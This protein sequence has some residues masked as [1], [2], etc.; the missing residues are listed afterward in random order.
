MQPVGGNVYHVCRAA[1]WSWRDELPLLWGGESP[2]KEE[3][4][5]GVNW[6]PREMP[7]DEEYAF[8]DANVEAHGFKVEYVLTP[9][10]QAGFSIFHP[11]LGGQ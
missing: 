2:D 9:T 6:W 7:S 3:R 11:A 10:P 4:D 8:C 1:S 5:P